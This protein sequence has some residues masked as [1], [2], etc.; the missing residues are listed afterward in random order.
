MCATNPNRRE[1]IRIFG[2]K[3]HG[4]PTY[5]I[6]FFLTRTMIIVFIW[7]SW[8]TGLHLTKKKPFADNFC[9]YNS[10]SS[11]VFIIYFYFIWFSVKIG[12]LSFFPYSKTVYKTWLTKVSVKMTWYVTVGSTIPYRSDDPR[13]IATEMSP[14]VIPPTQWSRIK[15]QK[16]RS[17]IKMNRVCP[18][19][20]ITHH[21]FKGGF[22]QNK[23]Q[24]MYNVI[25]YCVT[26]PGWYI[27]LCYCFKF[28]I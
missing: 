28:E 26:L 18:R 4:V 27:A 2:E 16:K 19:Q 12:Q 17:G 21:R 23:K 6:V 8:Q 25:T 14:H 20:F 24:K 22:T 15:K 9:W 5:I 10:K 7:K 11:H 3:G 1:V 13:D